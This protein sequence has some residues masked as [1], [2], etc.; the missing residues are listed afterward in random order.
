MPS[1]ILPTPSAP[2]PAA[3]R[4]G[5]ARFVLGVGVLAALVLVAVLLPLPDPM[6]LREWAQ[7]AGPAAALLF[8][9]GYAVITIA[10]IPRSLLTLT[11]GLLFGPL[12]GVT[13]ALAATAMG[14]A[15]AFGLV[16]LIGR[17]LVAP[18]LDRRSLLA[19]QARLRQRGWLAV[20]SLRLIPVVPFSVLNYCC[21]VSP[22]RLRHFIAGTVVGSAPGTVAVVLLGDAL[23]GKA[24][25][26]LLAVSGL[27]AAIGVA[28]LL[29][30]AWTPVPARYGEPDT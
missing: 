6:Q 5:R 22:I 10:P 3:P 12:T 2:H 23:T 17:D 20:T 26:T 19:V 28:G 11:A 30:D 13:V 29:I 27:F 18:W 16:R 7:S 4:A 25:P 8:L 1:S 24:S 14:A 21:A 9:L 15:L